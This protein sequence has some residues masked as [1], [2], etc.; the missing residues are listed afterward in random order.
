MSRTVACRLSG[1]VQN[2]ARRAQ[3]WSEESGVIVLV[4]MVEVVGGGGGGGMASMRA[5]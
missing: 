3:V 1:D 5:G 2:M 4:L